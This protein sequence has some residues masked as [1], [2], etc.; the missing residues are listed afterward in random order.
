MIRTTNLVNI[1]QTNLHLIFITSCFYKYIGIYLHKIKL[2][3]QHN[4]LN[5]LLS[6]MIEKNF[7]EV[8]ET[9]FKDN[10]DKPA[11]S[12]YG[13]NT[14][15]YKDL[16]REIALWHKVFKH[17]EI[18]KGDKI[19]LMGKDSAEWAI[20]FMSVI[21]YGAVIVPILQDFSAKDATHIINHSESK[22]LFINEHIYSSINISDITGVSDIIDLQTRK[23]LYSKNENLETSLE[24]ASR[25]FDAE[26]K[27][28]FEKKSVSYA[29]I[30]NSA[31]ILLNYTSGTTG[32]SKGVMVTANNLAGNIFF[33]KGK[34]IL[35][36]HYKM[37]SF[38]PMAHTYSCMTNLLL[39]LSEGVHITIL[40]KVPTPSILRVALG[41][42]KPHVVVSVP[43]VLEKIYVNTIAPI[44]N[45]KKLKVLLNIPFLK[46]ILY[47]KISKKLIKGLGGNV[48][49]FIVGGAALNP[50]VGHFLKKIKFPLTVGYGMTECAPLISYCH[51]YEWKEKSCG[52]VLEGYMKARIMPIDDF[53]NGE[54]DKS[55]G[56]IQVK[57]ENV[58]LGYYKNE[59][60]T[61]NL[62]T[63]DGWMR[64]GD[65]GTLDKDNFLYIKGRS[66]TMLLGSNGQN[67]YPEEI[68]AKINMI[69]Y[70]SESLV[71]MRNGKLEAL[72]VLDD[73]IIA[74]E[75]TCRDD[76]WKHVLDSRALVNEHLGSYEKIQ[77][78]NLN[79]KPFEKTPKQSIKR[80]LYK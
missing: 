12:N 3:V 71:V 49:Q 40:G 54:Y 16:A 31:M 22:M 41:A 80:F 77:A 1:I 57:G 18:S 30:P 28:G 69:K 53:E 39:S 44:I 73:N 27:D 63:E 52:R 34:K 45:R 62:F 74:K 78:F 7:I 4:K 29:H 79:D 20:I 9:S 36:P 68:E 13:G 59:K 42:I 43:L 60:E 6:I 32:F 8:Y 24:L 26:Y 25:D 5:I 23:P 51:P 21:T 19:A 58:C 50:E 70:V 38:L 72:I 76:A 61:A 46:D 66:K 15:M 14:Y 35:Q 65:L 33:C 47:K 2:S 10:W 11:L 64:T 37:L 17:L 75:N 55:V 56:E 48:E 67:I